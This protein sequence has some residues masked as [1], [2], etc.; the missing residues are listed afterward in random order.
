LKWKKK[1]RTTFNNGTLPAH[2]KLRSWIIIIETTHTYFSY[3]INVY[4]NINKQ[5][6]NTTHIP[7]S[8]MVTLQ[9]DKWA[10]NSWSKGYKNSVLSLSKYLIT[11]FGFWN[12]HILYNCLGVSK[13]NLNNSYLK[14][15]LRAGS[16][17]IQ[18]KKGIQFAFLQF[19]FRTNI[20]SVHTYMY[21]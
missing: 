19:L 13:S 8:S 11:S 7:N 4:L 12:K 15:V 17:K 3:T 21:I 20:Q 2:S 9:E 5:K 14:L 10:A 18:F 1:L 6:S 16:K